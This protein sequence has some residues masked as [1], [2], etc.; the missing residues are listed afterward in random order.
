MA[1]PARVSEMFQV[2]PADETLFPSAARADYDEPMVAPVTMLDSLLAWL[3]TL[4]I[5]ILLAG[6]VVV[7]AV[8]WFINL[9]FA[10]A[11]PDEGVGE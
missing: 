6:G 5:L 3:A 2:R 1:Y 9:F 4:G 11:A 8:V 7:A 10:T